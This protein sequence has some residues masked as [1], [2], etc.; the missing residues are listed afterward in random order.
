[1]TQR[2]L[3]LKASQIDIGRKLDKKIFETRVDFTLLQRG[4]ITFI[5]DDLRREFTVGLRDLPKDLRKETNKAL[6]IAIEKLEE[7]LD[8]AISSPVW[9]WPSG[10]R[11][12]IDTGALKD[13]LRIVKVGNGFT[14]KYEQP[15]AAICHNG[16]YIQPYGNP[17]ARPYYFTPRPWVA[18]TIEGGGRVK[19]FDFESILNEALENIPDKFLK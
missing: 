6:D 3:K 12:I 2:F 19:K 14:I 16:G 7:M 10:P 17:K 13:S 5:P 8:N 18:E 4:R 9:N 1:M 15:Y 11:D